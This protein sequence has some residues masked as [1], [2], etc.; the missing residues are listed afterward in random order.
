MLRYSIPLIP[1]TIFWWITSVSDRYMITVMRG[2]EANGIYTVANKIPT[3][4][5]LFSGVVMQAWQYEAVKHSK[6]SLNAQTAVY[7]NVWFAFSGLM[8]FLC[9]LMA[10][11]SKTG[12]RL[13]AADTYLVYGDMSRFCVLRCFSVRLH[14]LWGVY[15][16]SRKKARCHFLRHCSVP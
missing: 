14:R 16:P 8:F 13:I 3:M 12:I 7:G 11:L 1:T 4:L 5:T 6:H 15:T 10:A 2:S 9:S